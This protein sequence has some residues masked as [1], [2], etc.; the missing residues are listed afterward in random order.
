MLQSTPLIAPNETL[1]SCRTTRGAQ[2]GLPP[3]TACLVPW[4]VCETPVPIHA[5]PVPPL[6]TPSSRA[7]RWLW[8]TAWGANKVPYHS[9]AWVRL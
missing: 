6:S 1:A 3:P 8:L 2:W 4:G 7:L 9:R 5:F